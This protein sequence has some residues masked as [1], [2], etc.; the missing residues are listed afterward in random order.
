MTALGRSLAKE[1][2]NERSLS[3]DKL[4]SLRHEL[5]NARQ[6]HETLARP[7]TREQ[8]AAM[9]VAFSE[10]TGASEPGAEGISLYLT[11]LQNLPAVIIEDVKRDVALTHTYKRLPYP[12]EIADAAAPYRL[13][14]DLNRAN[15][16]DCLN[17]VNAELAKND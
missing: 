15:M 2:R 17:F 14:L 6:K 11:A 13:D 8:I 7:A 9:L 5:E 12:S 10:M 1:L 4:L 16:A 3:R